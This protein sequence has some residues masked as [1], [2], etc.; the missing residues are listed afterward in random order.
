VI[1]GQTAT[2]AS[3]ASLSAVKTRCNGLGQLLHVQPAGVGRVVFNQY[4]HVI[5]LIAELG[6]ETELG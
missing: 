1:F 2:S 3:G 4:H 5:A 6:R